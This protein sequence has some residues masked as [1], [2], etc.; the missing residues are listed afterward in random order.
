VLLLNSYTLVSSLRVWQQ[1]RE[2]GSLLVWI[3]Y[4]VISQTAA[5]QHVGKQFKTIVY[6]KYSQKKQ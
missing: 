1:R 3:F 2:V 5:C 4:N 6:V